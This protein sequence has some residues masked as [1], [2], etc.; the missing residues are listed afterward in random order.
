MNVAELGRLLGAAACVI[1]VGVGHAGNAQAGITSCTNE[2][3]FFD[4]NE[5]RDRG[6]GEVV[7]QLR[8]MV[9]NQV[10]QFLSFGAGKAAGFAPFEVMRGEAIIRDANGVL[11]EDCHPVIS[12]RQGAR[13]FGFGVASA[14]CD[15]GVSQRLVILYDDEARL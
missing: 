9:S 11:L 6:T 4:L 14:A 13:V 15:T 3:G 10:D 8:G 2:T 7:G 5:C 1:A 12:D